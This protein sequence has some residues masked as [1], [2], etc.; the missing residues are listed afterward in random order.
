MHGLTVRSGL[1]ALA[2]V[3]AGCPSVSTLGT[4]RTL[5]KGKLQVVVAPAL[6]GAA[7]DVAGTVSAGALPQGELVVRYGLSERFELGAKLWVGGMGLEGKYS[8]LKA[9]SMESGRDVSLGFVAAGLPVSRSIFDTEV[10]QKFLYF[11]VPLLFGFNRRGSQLVVGAKLL[12]AMTTGTAGTAS[13]F[14][15]GGS[16][17]YAFK[18]NDGV[19]LLPELSLAYPFF[20]ISPGSTW[21]G[22]SDVT[23]QLNFAILLGGYQEA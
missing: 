13:V 20:G 16:I 14:S 19:R 2:M 15:V 18:V 23:F 12:D 10:S 3:V 4:A 17:G 6:V 5:D 1:F 8:L 22:S 9:P 7:G 11:Q 21:L